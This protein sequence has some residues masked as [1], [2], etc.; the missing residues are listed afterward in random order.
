MHCQQ[1]W[2]D[3]TVG[4]QIYVVYVPE[5]P[6]DDT[7]CIASCF[8]VVP[9]IHMSG[10]YQKEFQSVDFAEFCAV[11]VTFLLKLILQFCFQKKNRAKLNHVR[12]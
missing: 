9:I 4:K 2:H 8:P 6:C 3:L 5:E 11:W 12:K 10:C 7:E 1:T